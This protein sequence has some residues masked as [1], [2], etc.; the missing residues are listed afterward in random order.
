[1]AYFN[2]KE[3]FFSPR[4][5]MTEG[6]GGIPY[7]EVKTLPDISEDVK[8]K[9]YKLGE[10]YYSLQN[11]KIGSGFLTPGKTLGW[12]EFAL[13]INNKDILTSIDRGTHELFTF[14]CSTA[15]TITVNYYG[16]SS[17]EGY[18]YFPGGEGGGIYKNLYEL[19]DEIYLSSEYPGEVEI[20]SVTELG[21]TVFGGIVD[22]WKNCI[23]GESYE[24]A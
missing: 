18:L 13:P 12:G 22:A 2:G 20:L 10:S 7:T 16:A 3:V 24:Q 21:A 23:T 15:G 1:M 8:G 6:G 14:W 11:N 9:V 19:Y 5:H 17:G 4:I